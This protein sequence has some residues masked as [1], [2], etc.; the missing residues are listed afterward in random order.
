MYRDPGLLCR[1]VGASAGISS[2]PVSAHR[3]AAT[4]PLRVLTSLVSE[5]VGLLV[6]SFLENHKS[7]MTA[8]DRSL[9]N[10]M[11]FS[12]RTH[13]T[14]TRLTQGQR[15]KYLNLEF[16]SISYFVQRIYL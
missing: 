2:P 8:N 7:E 16:S 14:D 6:K 4:T 13:P 15:G 12:S 1:S 10:E 3:C 5:L 9:S 11:Q